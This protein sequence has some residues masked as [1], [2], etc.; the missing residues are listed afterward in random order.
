MFILLPLVEYPVSLANTTIMEVKW[1]VNGNSGWLPIQEMQD[2][3][4]LCI[5]TY[6]SIYV[7]TQSGFKR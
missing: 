1:V 3:I 4:K 7:I 6:F 2:I 5:I